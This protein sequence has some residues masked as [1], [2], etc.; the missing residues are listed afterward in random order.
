MSCE[1]PPQYQVEDHREGFIICTLCSFVIDKVFS[2]QPNISFPHKQQGS[3]KTYK[4]SDCDGES[5]I[6][7]I[8][9]NYHVTDQVTQ[10]CLA[11]FNRARLR[12]KGRNIPINT[13]AAFAI[14]RGLMEESIPRSAQ[15]ILVMTGVDLTQ[16]FDVEKICD[17]GLAPIP[18]SNDFVERFGAQCGLS[19]QSI[20]IIKE[21]CALVNDICENYAPH[22]IAA[23]LIFMYDKK[24]T[25]RYVAEVCGVSASSI[26]KIVKKLSKNVDFNLK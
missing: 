24:L 25:T 21:K 7:D 6:K 2:F 26:Y 12:L 11:L 3:F 10:Q 5:A 15:E 20:K 19:Y 16:I 8:C 4:K 18:S 22:T 1:H 9:S 23:G 14:Y 13:I 17:M